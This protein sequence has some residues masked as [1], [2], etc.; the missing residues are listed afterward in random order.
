MDEYQEMSNLLRYRCLVMMDQRGK[1]VFS[2]KTFPYNV[3]PVASEIDQNNKLKKFVFRY[4]LPL[5]SRYRL[6]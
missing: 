4:F 6:D 3:R 5:C 1:M 2:E